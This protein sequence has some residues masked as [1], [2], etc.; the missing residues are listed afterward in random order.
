MKRKLQSEMMDSPH[1]SRAELWDS[2]AD[3]HA[4]NRWLGGHRSAR[5]RFFELLELTGERRFTVL[6][7]GTGGADIPVLLVEEARRR[8]IELEVVATD[9]HPD[10]LAFARQNTRQYPEISVQ[11]VDARDLPFAKDQF[12]VGLCCTALHHFDRSTATEVL[13][14]LDRV[15]SLGFVLTDLS[16]SSGAMVGA[17]ILAA[18]LWR[19]H[20]ITRHDGPVS[21]RSAYTP[22]ELEEMA[23]AAGISGA[24]V[25][26]ELVF[27]LSMVVD[28]SAAES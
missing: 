4:Y 9:I 14:E 20:P 7:V 15:S 12:D 24:R 8:G 11:K 13:T 26:H 2:L 23:R 17:R 18:T 28:R 6:D 5:K 21:V 27:R 19:R 10:T 22:C 25:H 3:L 16:R 1:A